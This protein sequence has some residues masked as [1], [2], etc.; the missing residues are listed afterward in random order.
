MNVKLTTVA[1]GCLLS[2]RV[3]AYPFLQLDIGGGLYDNAD[4][5]IYSQSKVFTLYA[6]ENT[7]SPA[8][9]ETLID[10]KFYISMALVPSAGANQ[11]MPAYGSIKVDGTEYLPSSS[12]WTYG[13]PPLDGEYPPL[14]PHSIFPAFCMELNFSFNVN[15]RA[16][17]YDVQYHPGEFQASSS[18]SF[19]Y[20]AFNIDVTQL[21][22]AYCLHFDLYRTSYDEK[23][24]KRVIKVYTYDT[25]FA[26]YSHDAYSGNL[27]PDSSTTIMLLGIALCGIGGLRSRMSVVSR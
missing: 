10:P 21:D 20:N 14:G 11:T 2:A 26:P 17:A 22:P 19:Y 9:R 7:E 16:T 13:T 4:Q 15:N 3:M 18:G 24:Q 27:V 5:S 6:L 1:I 12:S 25:D 23:L 8:F